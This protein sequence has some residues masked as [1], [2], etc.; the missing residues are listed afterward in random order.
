MS[1][2]KHREDQEATAHAFQEFIKT[3]Q[4]TPGPPNKLFVRA[5]ILNPQTGDE[6]V[7]QGKIYNP[8]ALIKPNAN[9][10]KNAIECARLLKDTKVE[11]NKAAE[12]PKS[13]L[14]L[15]KDELRMRHL[16]R[17]VKSRY[18]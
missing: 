11:K 18:N 9:T 13:N 1:K 7:E 12:K 3:F 15:L 2:R 17:G 14:E 4:D 8:T 10:L 5:G 6:D 16:E